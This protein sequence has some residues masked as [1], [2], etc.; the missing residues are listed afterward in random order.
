MTFIENG[1][2]ILWVLGGH[3]FTSLAR[4]GAGHRARYAEQQMQAAIEAGGK[5]VLDLATY[6]GRNDLGAIV[7]N[8]ASMNPY[9]AMLSILET[10]LTPC[11]GSPSVAEAYDLA[12]EEE[13]QA[14]VDFFGGTS[15]D[16]TEPAQSKASAG[17]NSGRSRK[18]G[19]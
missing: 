6:E 11:E 18:A 3:Q 7:Q 19:R 16:K 8:Y 1:R 4:V 17:K 2:R 10:V 12:T 5:S 9:K 14:V 15:N 13:V